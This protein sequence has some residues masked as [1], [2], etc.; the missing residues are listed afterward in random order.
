MN[1]LRKKPSLTPIYDEIFLEGVKKIELLASLCTC[2]QVGGLSA[3]HQ[4]L[5]PGC[6][7][8]EATRHIVVNIPGA[9]L[10]SSRGS[11]AN[12][13]QHDI[14]RGIEKAK[15]RAGA[16]G[17]VVKA[18]CAAD[19]G[20]WPHRRIEKSRVV[21]TAKNQHT[22]SLFLAERILFSRLCPKQYF[23]DS[24]NLSSLFKATRDGVADAL[25]VDDALFEVTH[26]SM[27]VQSG[28]IGCW[29]EQI[30][31]AWGVRITIEPATRA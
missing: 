19:A 23:C 9:M 4:P 18:L 27:P 28:T 15:H 13:R 31:C 10:L 20:I 30:D 17:L 2:G 22:G 24:D 21:W 12:S 29:Y 3:P 26:P 14:A 6:L 1:T 11:G 5:A 16:N 8:A 25:G 7:A